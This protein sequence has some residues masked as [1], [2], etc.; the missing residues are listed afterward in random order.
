MRWEVVPTDPS[1]VDS[2]VRRLGVSRFLASLLS[3]R[4]GTNPDEVERFLSP[5]LADF[6]DPMSLPGVSRAVD[7]VCKAILEQQRI[8]VYG[9]YDAD[10]ITSVCLLLTFLRD[11]GVRADYMLPSRFVDGYGLND[12][13]VR[14]IVELGYDLVITVDCGSASADEVRFLRE[15]G[16]DAVV[17]DHHQVR[18]GGPADALAFV[19]PY[20]WEDARYGVLAGV[21]VAFLL[22]SGIWIRLKSH[23]SFAGKLP[24]LKDYLD[25]VTMG[26][27]A[28]MVPLRGLSRTLVHHGLKRM[29]EAPLRP[30]MQ[31][32]REVAIQ[33]RPLDTSAVAFYMAPR[34]NAAGRLGSAAAAV[35]L[36]LS[37]AYSQAIPLARQLHEEN[38]RR[39]ALEKGI[40]E[41]ADGLLSAMWKQGPFHAAV[42]ASPDW[43]RGVLGIVASRLVERYFRPVVLLSVEGGEATGSG[44][45]IPGFD[46]GGALADCSDLLLRHGGHTMA[47]GLTLEVGRIEELTHRLEQL[48]AERVPEGNLL[49][50]LSIDAIVPLSQVDSSMVVDLERL[51]PYGMGNPEPVIG[52]RGVRV[53]SVQRVGQGAEHLKLKVE[54]DGR[55]LEAIWFRSPPVKVSVGDVVDLAFHPEIRSYLQQTFLQLRLKDLVLP[56]LGEAAEKQTSEGPGARA[57]N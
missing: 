14:E 5:R 17:T 37:P 8:V 20:T 3:A 46:L 57:M 27:V 26:T 44:R 50:R 30:G 22:V 56:G 33:G 51:V 34:L 31:A 2:L 9:D 52:V 38:D 13:R 45:S 49:P 19:N 54:Q 41:Q 28:D 6:A 4:V 55:V 24:N 53:V 23:P 16:V 40:F 48:V 25:L 35:D 36:L 7:R 32:L 15:N 39:K 12:A 10:G 43:H 29:S 1:A 42:L 21:G 11:L 47:A 18:D